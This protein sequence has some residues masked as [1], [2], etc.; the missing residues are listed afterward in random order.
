MIAAPLVERLL[1]AGFR[2]FGG[3][4]GLSAV[5]RHTFTAFQKLL[6][7]RGGTLRLVPLRRG[8]RMK[9]PIQDFCGGLYF[10][11]HSFEPRTAAFV[12]ANLRHGDVFVDVGANLGFYTLIAASVLRQKG[13]GHVLAF[14]PNPPVRGLLAES[15]RLSGLEAFV[16]ILPVALGASRSGRARFFLGDEH[17][18]GLS[19]LRP[20]PGH[21]GSG[22]LTAERTIEV[23][24]VSLDALLDEGRI[25]RADMLK[26]DVESAEAEVL[27]GGMR[28]LESLRPRHLICETSLDS[29]AARFLRERGYR[30]RLL[31]GLNPRCPLWGNVLFS[32]P[33]EVE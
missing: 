26:I 4:P 20:W 25:Q 14:E 32:M 19:T 30:A 13:G 29:D 18:S 10:N 3:L 15:V 23:E 11:P 12:V 5:S 27:V 1:A 8:V 16:T 6:A 21:L 22:A 28:L 31:E 9:L 17:N 2:C 33:N 7:T 24:C